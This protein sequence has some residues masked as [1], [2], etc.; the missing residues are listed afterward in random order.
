MMTALFI[1]LV[2]SV[3]AILGVAVAVWV[4]IRR[5]VG[6]A[7]GHEHFSGTQS[8]NGASGDGESI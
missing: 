7:P 3:L 5:K 4:R 2:L 1:V 6:A 8:E